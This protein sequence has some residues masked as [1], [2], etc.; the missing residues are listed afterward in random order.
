MNTTDAGSIK[1]EATV[2]APVEKVWK[3]WNDPQSIMKW[4]HAND[5]WHA[6]YAE[7]DLTRGGKFKTTMAAKDGSFSFDFEGV[8]D[9]VEPHKKIKY[10]MADGRKVAIEFIPEGSSTKVIE[11]FDPESINDVEMQRAGRQAILDSF[12]K[13]TEAG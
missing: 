8:Y 1:V 10:T 13:Y 2:H 5:D 7:N 9:L 11:T 4:C 3:S 6:P 12:K